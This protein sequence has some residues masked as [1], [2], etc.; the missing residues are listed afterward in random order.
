[1]WSLRSSVMKRCAPPNLE[2]C[3]GHGGGGSLGR[4]AGGDEGA[5]LVLAQ[6]LDDLDVEL[7]RLQ[8]D[9]GVGVDLTLVGEP[10][11]EPADRQLPGADRGRSHALVDELGDPPA[12]T[13][14]LQRRA[15]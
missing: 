15:H 2:G 8:P 3:P 7:G 13:V 9:E 5:E 10:G 14:P 1:M 11:G 4:L 6:R 12:Q